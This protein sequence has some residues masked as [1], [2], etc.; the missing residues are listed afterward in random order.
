MKFWNKTYSY[1]VYAVLTIEVNGEQHQASVSTV[2]QS[3]ER[4]RDSN[5]IQV[6]KDFLLSQNVKDNNES[7]KAVDATIVALTRLT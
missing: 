5:A 7:V 4:L 3:K 6:V 2:V 1:F